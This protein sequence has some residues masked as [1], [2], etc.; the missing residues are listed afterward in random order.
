M[1]PILTLAPVGAIG[2]YWARPHRATTEEVELL[3]A[4]ADSTSVAM[5]SVELL[6]TSSSA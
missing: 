6:S 5:E 4:L 3:A 1:M 2:V